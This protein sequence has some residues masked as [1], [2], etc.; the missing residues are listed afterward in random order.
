MN[1]V[2][3][4]P[5]SIAPMIDWSHTHFR[6]L[7]RLLAPSALLYTE[8]Q[9]PQAIKH[10]PQRALA[11][12]PM[13]HPIAL[14]LGGSNPKELVEA[15]IRAEQ[16]GYDEI[17]L[18]LGCPSNR[19]QAGNFGASLMREPDTV[20]SCVRAMKRS[21]SIPVTVKTRIGIDKQDSFDFFYNFVMRCID[22]GAE[23]V[24]VHARKAWLKGLNPKQNRTIPPI[25]YDYVYRLKQLV[26]VPVITNGEI[27][28]LNTIKEHLNQVD[29]VMLGRI[30]CCDPYKISKIHCG[31]YPDT[32]LLSRHTVMQ[33]YFNYAEKMSNAG[34]PISL[35]IKPIMGMAHGLPF[36]KQWKQKLLLSQQNKDVSIL[37]EACALLAE[38]ESSCVE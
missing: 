1:S 4:N 37:S 23:K 29:G 19:V 13:E 28:S 20:A 10:A 30:A 17:N 14:Q 12:D 32:P 11:Y 7:M 34:V 2:L 38:I 22:A 8:M 5:L 15:A 24:I 6:V 26:G 9:T 18:N 3:N 36:A 25:H 27:H 16:R 31:L 21:V 33:R 35:L